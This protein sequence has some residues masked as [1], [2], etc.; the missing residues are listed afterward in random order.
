MRDVCAETKSPISVQMNT[1]RT[2][3]PKRSINWLSGSDKKCTSEELVVQI[4]GAL[5]EAP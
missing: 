1:R 5:V 3:L 2:F 4:R